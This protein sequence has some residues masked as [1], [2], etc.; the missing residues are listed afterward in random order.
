M[1]ITTMQLNSYLRA[2]R[3]WIGVN[4]VYNLRQ[5]GMTA[6]QL[7]AIGHAIYTLKG[8]CGDFPS[9]AAINRELALI[10]F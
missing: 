9:L 2:D 3:E 1:K 10:K 4:D 5:Y 8:L 6:K 7:H